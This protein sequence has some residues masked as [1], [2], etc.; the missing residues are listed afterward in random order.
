MRN[1]EKDPLFHLIRSSDKSDVAWW[2]REILFCPTS[3][4]TALVGPREEAFSL[5]HSIAKTPRPQTRTQNTKR[6]SWYSWYCGTVAMEP[7]STEASG[8]RYCTFLHTKKASSCR[9][10]PSPAGKSLP[11]WLQFSGPGVHKTSVED[12]WLGT[13]V[14]V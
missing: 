13:V 12:R 10:R 11:L 7:T 3:T 4:Q 9:K 6:Y 2:P 14:F 5:H 1:F 8:A